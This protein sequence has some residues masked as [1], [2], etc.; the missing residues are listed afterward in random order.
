MKF[1][2]LTDNVAL[3]PE[4]IN[5]YIDIDSTL[6][7]SSFLVGLGSDPSELCQVDFNALKRS[8]YICEAMATVIRQEINAVLIAIA[9][10][11]GWLALMRW[12]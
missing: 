2:K 8:E 7:Q 9:N 5:D 1:V 3:V 11:Y 6:K 4:R 12:V 10:L